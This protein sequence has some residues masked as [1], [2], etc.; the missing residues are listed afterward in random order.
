MVAQKVESNEQNPIIPSPSLIFTLTFS[1][2]HHIFV[3]SFFK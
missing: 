2:T 3:W 1:Q